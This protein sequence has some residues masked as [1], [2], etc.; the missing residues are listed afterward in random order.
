MN[1]VQIPHTHT[2]THKYALHLGVIE[3]ASSTGL[4]RNHSG[5]LEPVC[6]DDIRVHGGDVQVVD[7]RAFL[8]PRSALESPVSYGY[9]AYENMV[10]DGL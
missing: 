9:G 8:A 2:H 3:V 4:F 6:K 10:V 1:A 7:R 5:G